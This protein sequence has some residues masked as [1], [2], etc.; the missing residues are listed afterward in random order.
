VYENKPK[1]KRSLVCSPARE[2][3]LKFQI[4]LIGA[5]SSIN[6][7]ITRNKKNWAEFAIFFT[8]LPFRVAPKK[9]DESSIFWFKVERLG[10]I[11]RALQREWR[12]AKVL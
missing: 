6:Q 1:A 8:F 5:E 7:S 11:W 10:K 2:N 12:R 4:G 3:F 9:I